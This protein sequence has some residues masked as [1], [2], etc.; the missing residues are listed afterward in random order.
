[1]VRRFPVSSIWRCFFPAVVATLCAGTAAGKP[2]PDAAVAPRTHWSFQPVRV[3]EPPSVKIEAWVR[4]PV[5]RFI[6]SKL[7]AKGLAPAPEASREQFIRRVTYGLTG[8]PP[9]PE[10][11]DAYLKDQEPGAE[12]RVVDRLLASPHYGERWARHWLD[13]V[14]YAE[15]DGYEHDTVRPHAWRYRD[16]VIR[17]FN[18]DKPYDRFVREQIA[19]DE[20][21]PDDRDA[22]VATAF[23]LLGPDMT[24]SADQTQRRLN[25]LNDAVDTTAAAF[26][27]LT[28]GCAR[29]H[30]HKFEPLT[31]RDYYSFQSFFAP[32]QFESE[33]KVPTED[34]KKAYAAAQTE[35]EMKTAPAREKLAALEG[36]VRERLLA[37][38]MAKLAP[39]V[40]EAH[41]TPKDK[42]TPQQEAVAQETASQVAVS[43]G[44]VKKSLAPEQAGLLAKINAEIKAVPRPDP[45]PATM[46][47]RNPSGTPAAV[48]VLMRGDYTS[49]GGEV[50]PAFPGVLAN[51]N[52]PAAAAEAERVRATTARRAALAEWIAGPDNTLTARVMVNRIW[53]HHF[54]RGLTRSSGDFGTQGTAPTHPELLDWLAHEFVTG[55]WSVKKIHRLIVL[56][57]AYRQGSAPSAAALASDP[58]NSLFSRQNRV[59]LE[60]EAIRDS[61]LAVSG[62]L[63]SAM[64]GPGVLP[65]IPKA[66]T[67]VSKN[68][69]T[70]PDK[71]EH[72]RRSIYIFVR[73]NLRFPFLEVFDAPDSNISCPE[74]G[75]STTA[76]QALSLLNSEETSASATAMAARLEREVPGEGTEVTGQRIRL[77]FRLVLG[78]PPSQNEFETSAAF[79]KKESGL[80]ELCRALLNLNAFIYVD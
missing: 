58:D 48:H 8:L 35:W 51:S 16:Y 1:M 50:Q 4:T 46:A 70:T 47:L 53:Q 66:I 34:E 32:A 72:L 18:S 77:A 45:L 11:I 75:R 56:S 59:R 10:E 43:E 5:D 61:L 79:L 63:N 52:T 76:P 6:L 12:E 7:E 80:S 40:Q 64:F 24:D 67:A 41:R 78:R 54:G 19:G 2:P 65:P 29:C 28:L 71:A 49:P 9:S 13:L 27:G 20:L 74:R 15:T 17:S 60:G 73:R 3:A 62:R 57:S 23:A 30:D 38:K 42:R 14:R 33:L 26:L 21:W 69:N 22:R 55:G 39:E 68:W 44:E 37:A 36:P 25:T 31:Q